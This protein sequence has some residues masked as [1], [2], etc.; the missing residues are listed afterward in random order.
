MFSP[1]RATFWRCSKAAGASFL[2]LF[3]KSARRLS[4]DSISSCVALASGIHEITNSVW[5][6]SQGNV[7]QVTFTSGI[8]PITI[9]SDGSVGTYVLVVKKTT[10]CTDC[11]IYF[12]GADVKYPG[13]VNPTLS[14]G[15]NT[16][17]I[18]SFVAVANNTF[19]CL[20]AN[21]LL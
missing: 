21:N 1:E 20:Y 10:S 4:C 16:T 3:L 5:D 15:S 14:S 17:D 19:Y 12:L 9:N 13:G 2:F 6:L 7:A 11:N 18:F 8:T